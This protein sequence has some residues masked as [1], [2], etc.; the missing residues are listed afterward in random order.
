MS[1]TTTNN[2][3]SDNKQKASTIVKE[4]KTTDKKLNP[5]VPD[6]QDVYD[7]DNDDSSVLVII[8]Q[9][10]TKSCDANISNLKWAFSDPYFTVQ[11]C[12]VDPPTKIPV[13]KTITSAQYLE[14]YNMRKALMY[15]AE[16]PYISNTQGVIEPQF[17]WEKMPVIIIKDSS[18]TNLTPFGWKDDIRSEE[19]IIGGMKRR[20][21]I[22]LEKATGADLFFLCKWNDACDKYID[23]EGANHINHGSSLKWS[24]QPTAT[25]AIMYS[26]SGREFVQGALAKNTVSMSDMVNLYIARGDIMA[27]VFVPNIMDFDVELATSNNDYA[28]LNECAPPQDTTTNNNNVAALVWLILIVIMVILVAWGLIQLNPLTAT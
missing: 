4:T 15:A 12:A 24:K 6:N 5:I 18:I 20:I 11:V 1:D 17:W 8:L 7:T 25:Q 27:T 2:Q 23:V 19:Q 13:S 22:A 10:E 26:T 3:N 9:C 28:K 16:G 14:N 21:K